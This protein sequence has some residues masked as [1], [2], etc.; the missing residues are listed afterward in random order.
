MSYLDD[1]LLLAENPQELVQ[2]VKDTVQMFSQL[3]FKISVDKSQLIPTKNIEFLEFNIDTSLMKVTMMENKA[4]KL[5]QHCI[6]VRDNPTL[7]LRELAQLLGHMTASMPANST[8]RLYSKN[9]EIHKIRSLKEQLGNFEA[10]T[11]LPIKAVQDL[12]WW[13]ANIEQTESEIIISDPDLVFYTDASHQGW[14]CHA[15]ST[16]VTTAGRW[17][18]E[19]QQYHINVLELYAVLYSLQS[20]FPNRNREHLRVMTDNTTTMLCIN[21]QRST[22]LHCNRL[23]RDIWDW[24]LSQHIWISAAHCP[25][26]LNV[27]ADA[28]SR[29]FHDD[30]EWSL[31]PKIFQNICDEFGTPSIDAFASRLNKQ[32]PRYISWHPDPYAEAV[33]AFSLNWSDKFIY[34][35]PPFSLLTGTIQKIRKDAGEAVVV[36]PLWP[37]QPWLTQLLQMT[38][39]PPLVFNMGKDS[40]RL[41]HKPGHL[42]PM[43]NKLQLI[44]CHCSGD[45]SWREDFIQNCCRHLRWPEGPHQ[46]SNTSLIWPSGTH[47]AQADILI[48]LNLKYQRHYCS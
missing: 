28:A 43:D 32:I 11:T 20:L 1:L 30:T 39:E 35:F 12:D 4:K 8:A 41:C 34:T 5:V 29:T 21:N 14:G 25:G 13:I 18:M 26:I 19:E 47:L 36:A 44:A 24:C 38:V 42:H 6:Q 37:N 3:G 27:E 40:L 15:P 7:T 22:S 48:P 9:L 31:H 16:N 33:D 10:V 23:A 2:A 46:T 17:T 45:L